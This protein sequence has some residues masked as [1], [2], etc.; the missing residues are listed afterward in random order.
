MFANASRAAVSSREF[1][2]SLPGARSKES[3]AA[4]LSATQERKQKITTRRFLLTTGTVFALV[5]PV[6]HAATAKN[7]LQKTPTHGVVVGKRHVTATKNAADITFLPVGTG[8]PIEANT[9]DDYDNPQTIYA[10]PQPAVAPAAPDP[11]SIT[12]QNPP[13]VDGYLLINQA[14]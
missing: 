2:A 1:A 3:S 4:A 13:L 10:S 7:E 14:S 9:S 11:S 5:V 12:S 8:T 6:A